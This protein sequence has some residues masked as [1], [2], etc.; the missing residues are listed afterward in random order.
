MRL[1][2]N[3]TF[4]KIARDLIAIGFELPGEFSHCVCGFATGCNERIGESEPN[5]GIPGGDA[6]SQRSDGARGIHRHVQLTLTVGHSMAYRA[7]EGRLKPVEHLPDSR[8]ELRS[9]RAGVPWS[10]SQSV[11]FQQWRWAATLAAR[12][13]RVVLHRAG[14]PTHGRFHDA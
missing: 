3:C 9:L 13:Q 14:W 10:W 11:D 4:P 12:R 2:R 6:A 7:V 1:K 5:V 8:E